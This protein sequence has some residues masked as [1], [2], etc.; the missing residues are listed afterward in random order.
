MLVVGNVVIGRREE[1]GEKGRVGSTGVGAG[2]GHG[3]G[4]EVGLGSLEQEVREGGKDGGGGWRGGDGLDLL[5]EEGG[6][7]D[8]E[9]DLLLGDGVKADDP[10]RESSLLS[11]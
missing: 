11:R 5:G 3:D 10:G 2:D 9:G 1:G 8:N 4:D 7:G 6:D